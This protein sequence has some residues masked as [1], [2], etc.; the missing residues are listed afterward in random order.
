MIKSTRVVGV[1]TVCK[2]YDKFQLKI[3]GVDVEI[4]VSRK[5]QP[6]FFRFMMDSFRDEVTFDFMEVDMSC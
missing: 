6:K 1:E 3:N 2:E 4:I 5:K